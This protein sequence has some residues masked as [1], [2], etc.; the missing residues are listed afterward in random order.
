MLGLFFNK[1]GFGNMDG[2]KI[3]SI[4]LPAEVCGARSNI[5]YGKC[6]LN[7]VLEDFNGDVCLGSYEDVFSGE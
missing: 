1:C 4:K 7:N 2:A 3:V 5:S 6:I